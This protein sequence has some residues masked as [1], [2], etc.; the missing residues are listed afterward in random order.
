MHGLRRGREI[1]AR[2]ETRRRSAWARSG[3]LLLSVHRSPLDARSRVSFPPQTPCGLSS[4]RPKNGT[5][6]IHGS[7]QFAGRDK[8]T[9]NHLPTTDGRTLDL[10]SFM[11]ASLAANRRAGALPHDDDRRRS[12]NILDK[13]RHP[14]HA[15]SMRCVQRRR[16]YGG[17]EPVHPNPSLAFRKGVPVEPPF[18]AS[19]RR[20]MPSTLSI[21]IHD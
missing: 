19:L 10:P 15:A 14:R 5:E 16:S 9:P 21:P 18:A 4:Q 20:G 1:T 2:P 12:R 6:G 11:Q 3:A 13:R 7:A 8:I 17:A